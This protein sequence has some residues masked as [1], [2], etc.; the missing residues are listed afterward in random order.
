MNDKVICDME[1][2]PGNGVYIFKAQILTDDKWERKTQ[3]IPMEQFIAFIEGR[4]AIV[5]KEK[6]LILAGV[7]DHPF[8]TVALELKNLIK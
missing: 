2:Y 4:A 5:D 6:V 8:P 7:L 3:T 1:G